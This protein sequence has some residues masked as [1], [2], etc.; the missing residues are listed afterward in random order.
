MFYTFQE[1]HAV[2]A[3]SLE[4]TTLLTNHSTTVENAWK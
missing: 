4:S 3:T 1:Q 2:I